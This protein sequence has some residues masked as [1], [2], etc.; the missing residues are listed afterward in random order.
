[1]RKG[2]W[3][4]NVQKKEGER[5]MKVGNEAVLQKGDKESRKVA[6]YVGRKVT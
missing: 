1:M 2:G 5:D 3:G 6:R 4:G